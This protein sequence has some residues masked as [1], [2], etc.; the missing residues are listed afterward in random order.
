MEPSPF[1]T[2]VLDLTTQPTSSDKPVDTINPRDMTLG[3]DVE[4]TPSESGTTSSEDNSTSPSH[5]SE[6]ISKSAPKKRKKWGQVLPEPTTNLPPRKRA[7]TDEEKQQRKYERVKRNRQAAHNSRLRKQE[8]M[9]KLYAE[10]NSLKQ[11]INNFRD[12]I[13]RLNDENARL[14]KLA[15]QPQPV[16]PV[17]D[18]AQTIDDMMFS[19]DFKTVKQELNVLT[20]PDSPRSLFEASKQFNDTHSAEMWSSPQWTLNSPI[21]LS[22]DK[23]T[24]MAT[25]TMETLS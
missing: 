9:D 19:A 3:D 24:S 17:S 1:T 25:L 23:S 2:T 13:S 5:S 15:S 21:A 12:E 11:D 10:N 6:S 14:S 16:L 4:G 8:E 7:K 18:T 20:P 22:E